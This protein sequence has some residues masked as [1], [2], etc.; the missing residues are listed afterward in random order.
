MKK[1]GASKGADIKLMTE[2]L[3]MTTP[4]PSKIHHQKATSPHR[5]K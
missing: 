4:P 3:K 5:K 1:K 2:G